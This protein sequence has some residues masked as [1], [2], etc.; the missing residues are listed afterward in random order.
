MACSWTRN[1]CVGRVLNRKA[2]RSPPIDG[3][4]L[5]IGQRAALV[6]TTGA[7]VYGLVFSPRAVPVPVT[8]T[9]S[10]SRTLLSTPQATF[11]NFSSQVAVSLE[12]ACN[13]PIVKVTCAGML[14]EGISK[15]EHL[16]KL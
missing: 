14:A 4:A 15:Q 7:K 9:K 2:V 13:F 3:F 8:T 12:G 6:P 16:M 1:S 11:L 5:R 10:F